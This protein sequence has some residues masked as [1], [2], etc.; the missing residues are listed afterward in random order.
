LRRTG[1]HVAG[2][3]ANDIRRKTRKLNGDRL[4]RAK[5]PSGL[6]VCR[7][8]QH[9]GAQ[10]SVGEVMSIGP[11]QGGAAK[12]IRSLEPS[13]PKLP[14]NAD[15]LLREKL[16]T[17]RPNRIHWILTVERGF[18]GRNLRIDE[19]RSPVHSRSK[20]SSSE[21]ARGSSHRRNGFEGFY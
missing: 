13:T 14:R 12:G 2:E 9:S 5:F 20:R 4:C 16:S 10:K 6:K 17:P 7:S 21:P 3:I 8:G 18:R 19:D 1:G 11:I 15:S